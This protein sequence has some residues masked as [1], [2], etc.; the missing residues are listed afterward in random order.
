MNL[1]LKTKLL[2]AKSILNKTSDTSY[3]YS[4]LEK[5]FGISNVQGDEDARD[6]LD[7]YNQLINDLKSVII[8]YEA[9]NETENEKLHTNT[10]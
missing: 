1:K 4:Q 10:K 8:N 6:L 9:E 2:R 3:G 7:A 5:E